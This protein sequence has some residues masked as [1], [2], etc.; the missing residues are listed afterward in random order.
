MEQFGRFWLGVYG[1]ALRNPERFSE[2]LKQSIGDWLPLFERAFDAAGFPPEQ[3]S[4]SW[5]RS[6]MQ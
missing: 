1:L 6:Y 2:F 3:R 5:L 4:K